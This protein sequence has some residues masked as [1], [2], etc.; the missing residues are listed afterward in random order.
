MPNRVDASSPEFRTPEESGASDRVLPGLLREV[1]S[2]IRDI[3]LARL[4]RERQTLA[5]ELHQIEQRLGP[6]HSEYSDA[7]ESLDDSLDLGENRADI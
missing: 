5:N 4:K 1:R 6:H 7:G 3:T 2:G